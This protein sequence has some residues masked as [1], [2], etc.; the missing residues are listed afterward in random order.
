[1]FGL[2]ENIL[3][4]GTIENIKSNLKPGYR[5]VLLN[6]QG[7]FRQEYYL[8]NLEENIDITELPES[9]Y[10]IQVFKLSGEMLTYK[11]FQKSEMLAKLNL[12]IRNY[13][14]TISSVDV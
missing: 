8:C 12:S 1:M 7:N 10:I 11:I 6:I 3:P 4:C 9:I 13:N 2:S 5:M 14:L